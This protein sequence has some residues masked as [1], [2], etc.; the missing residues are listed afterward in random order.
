LKAKILRRKE[1]TKMKN[2]KHPL[3]YADHIEAEFRRAR[4]WRGIVYGLGFSAMIG[5]VGIGLFALMS[6]LLWV[7]DIGLDI[8]P[9][10]M[11]VEET[12]GHGEGWSI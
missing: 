7:G 5:A 11:V 10:V 2:T 12:A 6:A 8:V 9:A 1:G 4:L 3:L